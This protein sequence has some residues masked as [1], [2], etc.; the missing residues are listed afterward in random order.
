MTA[1]R[2]SESEE[3]LGALIVAKPGVS[4]WGLRERVREG[5]IPSC[6]GLG[7]CAPGKNFQITD[8]RRGV[9]A[10]FPYK[11]QY[12]AACIY[13]CKLWKNFQITDARRGVLAHFPYKSL[14][15]A[16]CKRHNLCCFY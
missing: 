1:I 15:I 14:Y 5:V 12:I 11:N 4:K 8:A 10:H 6:W 13:A 16:A 2:A 3:R 9:L 7:G